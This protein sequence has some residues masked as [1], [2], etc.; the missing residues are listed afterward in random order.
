MRM[1][2]GAGRL[3][4]YDTTPLRHVDFMALALWQLDHLPVVEELVREAHNHVVDELLF[5]ALQEI[6]EVMDRVIED[7]LN[8]LVLQLWR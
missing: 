6:F 7:L 4:D 8:D 2:S 3:A 5:T 1:D